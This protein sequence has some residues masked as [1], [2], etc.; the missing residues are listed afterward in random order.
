MITPTS[1]GTCFISERM[2]R[3]PQAIKP[4]ARRPPKRNLKVPL[5]V[6]R[7]VQPPILSTICVH[8]TRTGLRQETH[9]VLYSGAC[10]DVAMLRG[11]S[12]SIRTRRTHEPDAGEAPTE[13]NLVAVYLS[14]AGWNEFGWWHL[15]NSECCNGAAGRE[16]RLGKP[17]YYSGRRGRPANSDDRRRRPYRRGY[18]R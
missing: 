4:L 8:H 6:V 16:L 12:L 3:G 11:W 7:A 17:A 1:E 9:P 13:D 18:S 15:P 14:G 10:S 5:T 2:I